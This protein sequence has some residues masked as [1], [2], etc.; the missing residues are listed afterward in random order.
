MCGH[1]WYQA[2]SSC[3]RFHISQLTWAVARKEC[4]KLGGFLATLNENSIEA[5]SY[6]F[7]TFAVNKLLHTGFQGRR[8]WFWTSTKKPLRPTN[9]WGPNAPSGDGLCGSFI[10]AKKWNKQ[11]TQFYWNDLPCTFTEAY[12]CQ[13]NTSKH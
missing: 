6:I 5:A 11:W 1:G 10:N 13:D 4:L 7:K 9:L 12:I 2:N 3:I 8:Y